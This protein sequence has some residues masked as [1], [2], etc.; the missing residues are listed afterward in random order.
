MLVEGGTV[1]ADSGI[2]ERKAI[3]MAFLYYTLKLHIETKCLKQ[4]IE[5]AIG[6]D[7]R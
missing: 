4:L 7:Y 5:M 6:T 3:K 1:G 2:L